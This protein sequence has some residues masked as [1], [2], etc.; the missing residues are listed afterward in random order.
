MRLWGRIRS[1]PVTLVAL[2]VLAALVFMAIFPSLVATYNPTVTNLSVA[3]QGPS[4]RHLLGTDDV[5]RDVFS[6]LVYS[7]RVEFGSMA[8][9]LGVA[10]GVGLPIGMIA[11]FFGGWFDRAIRTVAEVFFS[12]PTVL[13]AFGFVAMFGVSIL[14]AMLAL[15]VVFSTRYIMLG[16][17]MCRSAREEA[18]VAGAR[19]LG[20]RWNGIM[21]RHILPNILQPLV[22]Q[23]S[24]IMSAVILIEAELSYLGLAAA[25]G[26]ATWGGMLQEAQSFFAVDAF[27]PFPPGLAIVLTV[28]ALSLAGDG[29][30]DALVRRSLPVH[31]RRQQVVSRPLAPAAVVQSTMPVGVAAGASAGSDGSSTEVPALVV[32]DLEVA[33]AGPDGSSVNVV[34]G[35]SLAVRPG[36]I[37]CIAGESGSGKTMT[38]LAA[39][40]IQ[41]AAA[42][43][44]AGSVKLFGRELFGLKQREIRGVLGRDVG[45][46]FQEPISSLNPTMKIGAQVAEPLRV[47]E[48]LSKRLARSR[49]VE[50][51][52]LVGIVDPAG[53]L[54][55]YPHQFSGGMA[56]RVAIARAVAC[57]PR[58]LLA[59]EPTTA[60]DV[61]VQG[62]LLDLLL[63]LRDEMNLAVIL[64]THDLGV[65]ADLADRM[66]VLYAGQV[67]EAGTSVEVFA[68]CQHPYTAA[69]LAAT[70]REDARNG[71]LAT[72][73]GRVP[74]AWEWGRACRF[75]DRCQFAGPGC[76]DNPVELAGN[77][78]LVRCVKAKSLTLQGTR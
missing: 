77:G 69:L 8:I 42:T 33:I 35:V 9:A 32:A 58:V 6:R 44:T 56:Q 24:V 41:P 48:G 22:V 16:R 53:R 36:E 65:C 26:T 62:Q 45:F 15:G 39:L 75:L 14:H 30:S 40:G 47:H 76:A 17:S 68:Q 2:A 34:D 37:L 1:R 29:I 66:V 12:I 49:V 74:P 10:I 21:F 25:P 72:I 52:D 19:V 67:V 54:D 46:V 4:F 38:L 7:D 20:L 27:L 13:V 60:L 51:L 71:Q 61:T 3:F 59:D 57:R 18:Y 73:P 63:K 64:V 43:V 11:G 31:G 78:H 70:P 23:T 5:G 28:I 50:L 55:D